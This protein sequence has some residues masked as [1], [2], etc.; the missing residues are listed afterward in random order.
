VGVWKRS[1]HDSVIMRS[2]LA[3]G[4]Y[5]LTGSF[6]CSSCHG[7]RIACKWTDQKKGQMLRVVQQQLGSYTFKSFKEPIVT[8]TP[9]LAQ[10]HTHIDTHLSS[11]AALDISIWL[12][13]VHAALLSCATVSLPMGSDKE[14][15]G[16]I[17]KKIVSLCDGSQRPSHTHSHT[18]YSISWTIV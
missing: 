7:N 17:S 1:R 14:K 2:T 16:K 18:P 5:T 4:Q 12:A 6:L 13:Q 8:P 15:K 9:R 10:S 11:I 3:R